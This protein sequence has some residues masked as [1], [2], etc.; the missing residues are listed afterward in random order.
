MLDILFFICRTFTFIPLSFLFL[1]QVSNLIEKEKDKLHNSRLAIF[2]LTLGLWIDST[3][4]L[5][6]Y[7]NAF[8]TGT[9]VQEYI[10]LV[11]TLFLISKFGM[12][13]SVWYLYKLV[14]QN[15]NS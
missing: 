15:E 13:G 7:I 6:G 2:L 1:A 8:F 9:G 12:M 3:L 14:Y 11:Q 10:S 4:Y 5:S